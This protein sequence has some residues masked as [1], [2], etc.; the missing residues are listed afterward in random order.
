MFRSMAEV[1]N[2]RLNGEA[3]TKVFGIWLQDSEVLAVAG[4][5]EQPQQHR[6]ADQGYMLVPS[7]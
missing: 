4:S 2:G 1:R 5:A 7:H 6:A 3:L